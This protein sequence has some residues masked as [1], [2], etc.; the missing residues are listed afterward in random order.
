MSHRIAEVATADLSVRYLLR[1]QIEAL[2]DEGF[3]VEAVCAP[4][5]HLEGLAA[6]GLVLHGVPMR[7]ELAPRDDLRSFVELVRLFRE[8]RYDVVITHTPKAGLLAPAA[9]RLAAVPVVIHTVHGFLFH[10]RMPLRHRAL[11]RLVEQ[12][13][14]RFAHHLFF[15]SRED[16]ERAHRAVLKRRSRLD[17]V[18]NGIETSAFP[19]PD[20]R[21]RREARGRLGLPVDS[22]VVGT[23]GR[24]VW[25]KGYAELMAA[26]TA[27]RSRHREMVFVAA[28]PFEPDQSDGLTQADVGRAEGGGAIRFVGHQDDMPAFYA[29][30][31]LFVLPSHREGIPR[32]LM[33][34]SGTGL[35]VVA[36]DIR[37]C[38][39]V[40]DPGVTGLLCRVRDGASLTAGIEELYR[41]PTRRRAMGIAGRDRI[42]AQFDE[43][44]VRARWAAAVRRAI[45]DRRSRVAS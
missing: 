9:A 44:S 24:L 30:L 26:A 29:A 1:R 14:A 16:Y 20:P 27:L 13:P 19:V 37:G 38:R 33:E 25:E 42:L 11:G 28:G 18:G 41:D 21:R 23:V 45:G 10:D 2:G 17:Y 8:R 7:R 32:S 39:E 40:V 3:E 31:D 34:A 35:A 22:F 12:P 4:G 6:S 15:Q 43:C 5:P 36:S